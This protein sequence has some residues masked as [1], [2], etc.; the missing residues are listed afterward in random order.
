[1]TRGADGRRSVLF[2]IDVEPDA[3][4][5]RDGAGAWAGSD[6][7]IEHV[8]R[9][10]TQL[11]AATGARVQLNW[12][13]RADP[14]IQQTWGRADWVAEACPRIIRTIADRGDYSGIHPHLWRWH[15][16]RR[17]WFNELN[18]PAWTS[19]CLQIAVVAYERMF[20]RA[21]EACRFGD[22]W[23]DQRAVELLRELGI[24]YD[25]TIEPGMA[26]TPIHDDPHATGW[27]PDYRSAQREPY[28]PSSENFLV[29]TKR[30]ADSTSLWMI[31]LTTTPPEWRL[32]RRPPYLLKASRSPNLALSS[33]Y[34]WPGIRDQLEHGGDAPL[35]MALR[36]GDLTNRTFLR[37]F[38]RTTS[39]LVRHPMLERCEFTNPATAIARW[40]AVR[41]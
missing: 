26:D 22:R 27:L 2:L 31:P 40:Q 11:E 15:V 19:E 16:Q 32:V 34:V 13:L 29:P 30:P 21:P 38:L 8:E 10:R 20:G 33:S 1:M 36:S 7:A 25:L 24:R 3:R 39:E 35:S 6:A 37:N 28:V 41:R 18:D 12:F 5:T 9:L 14:Q 17:E 23:L 4:K